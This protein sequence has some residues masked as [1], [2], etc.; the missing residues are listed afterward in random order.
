VQPV[1]ENAWRRPLD[2]ACSVAEDHR[3]SNNEFRQ[4]A[5]DAAR[6]IMGRARQI[7]EMI[8]ERLESRRYK[9]VA[10]E[11]IERRPASVVV[12]WVA[13]FESQGIYIPISLQAELEEVGTVN[14]MGTTKRGSAAVIAVFTARDEKTFGSRTRTLSNL[15]SI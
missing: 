13:E 12:D 4:E 2:W 15:V 7:I 11:P 3:L 9:F 14:L 6:A 10:S 5:L 8:A 1:S